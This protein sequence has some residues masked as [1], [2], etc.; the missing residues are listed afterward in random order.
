MTCDEEEVQLWQSEFGSAFDDECY[1]GHSKKH[2]EG[3][4]GTTTLGGGLNVECAVEDLLG[5]QS[6]IHGVLVLK[7]PLGG[8]VF[9]VV[10]S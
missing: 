5:V 6:L 9:L 10:N 2:R 1:F 8:E 3:K 4:V 7:W